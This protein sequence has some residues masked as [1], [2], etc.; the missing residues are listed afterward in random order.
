M[1]HRI[2][3]QVHENLDQQNSTGPGNFLNEPHT[4]GLSPSTQAAQFP[5]QSLSTAS[6]WT[7]PP[8]LVSFVNLLEGALNPIV[9][10][11]NKDAEQDMPQ[12]WAPGNSISDQYILTIYC[13]IVDC[14][15]CSG[16]FQGTPF[17]KFCLEAELYSSFTIKCPSGLLRSL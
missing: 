7:F 16:F 3:N 8:N 12:H 2:F 4:T 11:I 1:K 13:W 6:R 5:L 15:H 9:Q 14:F 10:T 17:F